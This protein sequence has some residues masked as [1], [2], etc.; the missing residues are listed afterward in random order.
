[1]SKNYKENVIELGY[2][3]I[4]SLIFRGPC[5][6]EVVNTGSDGFY[7]GYIV[8]ET[9]EIPEYYELVFETE[10]W[11]RVYDDLSLVVNMSCRKFKIY[12]AGRSFIIQ[13]AGE[14]TVDKIVASA[15]IDG[16]EYLYFE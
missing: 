15:D 14:Y 11:L 4:A 16:R 1:M 9:I 6:A 13:C 12:N 3:D 2:S 10:H 5:K 8:D 7:K